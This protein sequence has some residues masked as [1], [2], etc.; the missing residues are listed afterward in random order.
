[1]QTVKWIRSDGGEEI[2][3]ATGT[4]SF[5]PPSPAGATDPQRPAYVSFD[6]AN[7]D[8]RASIDNGRVFVM[9]GNGKTVADYE[10]RG[11]A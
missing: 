7:S 10:L 8:I 4:V 2:M 3:I 9:N 1:M 5:N 11:R 6:M